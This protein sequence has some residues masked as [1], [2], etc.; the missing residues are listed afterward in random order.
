MSVGALAD[1]YSGRDSE[2]SLKSGQKVHIPVE[3]LFGLDNLKIGR[4]SKFKKLL[5][6]TT[7]SPASL[8]LHRIPAG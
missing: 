2:D 4:I 3:R 5:L 7:K 8:V 1:R 6:R